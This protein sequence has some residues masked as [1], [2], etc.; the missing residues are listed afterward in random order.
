MNNGLDKNEKWCDST[1]EGRRIKNGGILLAMLALAAKLRRKDE[2]EF[3][4]EKHNN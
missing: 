4:N 3:K 2:R 1:G